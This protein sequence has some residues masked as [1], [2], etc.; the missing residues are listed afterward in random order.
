[1]ALAYVPSDGAIRLLGE[2]E[3]Y[4]YDLGGEAAHCEYTAHTEFTSQFQHSINKQLQDQ[5]LR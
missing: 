4:T 3:V 5:L 1:M 2:R